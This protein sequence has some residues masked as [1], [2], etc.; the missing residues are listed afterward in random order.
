MKIDTKNHYDIKTREIIATTEEL[1]L[2]DDIQQI[3][4]E[5]FKKYEIKLLKDK[6]DEISDNEIYNLYKEIN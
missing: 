1:N 5:T 2:N 4:F 3:N 6:H